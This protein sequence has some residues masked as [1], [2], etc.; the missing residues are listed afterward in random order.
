MKMVSSTDTGVISE[1]ST[2]AVT[3]QSANML[4]GHVIAISLSCII[5]IMFALGGVMGNVLGSVMTPV[6]VFLSIFMMLLEVLVC[7]IQAMVFTMLSAVFIS[8]SHVKEHH[9]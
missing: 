6:S 8:M 2:S 5:F 3:P 4:A 1:H 9:A 7:Y